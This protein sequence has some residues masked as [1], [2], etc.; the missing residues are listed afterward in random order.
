[1]RKNIQQSES[2]ESSTAP[3]M[4][5]ICRPHDSV[6][7]AKKRSAEARG[8]RAAESVLAPPRTLDQEHERRHLGCNE[9]F[10]A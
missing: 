3:V 8:T 1:M 7:L 9:G 2:Y 6:R 4:L 5:S 10:E